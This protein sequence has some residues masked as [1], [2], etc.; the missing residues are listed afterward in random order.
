[1]D[2][3]HLQ[4]DQKD[5]LKNFPPLPRGIDPGVSLAKN[6]I[7]QQ[8]CSTACNPPGESSHDREATLP[9]QQIRLETFAVTEQNTAGDRAGTPADGRG[10]R[11]PNCHETTS[12]GP[13][14]PS[15]PLNPSQE[16]PEDSRLLRKSNAQVPQRAHANPHLMA[17]SNPGAPIG[18]VPLEGRASDCI[19]QPATFSN[20][21]GCPYAPPSPRSPL[22][23][24]KGVLNCPAGSGFSDNAAQGLEND[25]GRDQADTSCPEGNALQ[26]PP[27]PMSASWQGQ[28][29]PCSRPA[30]EAV[31]YQPG[32]FG[33][34]PGRPQR[35]GIHAP[36][37][38]STLPAA[39]NKRGLGTHIRMCAL[40]RT[41]VS[42]H[43]C[44]ES[45]QKQGGQGGGRGRDRGQ[46]E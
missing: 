42:G 22:R 9:V 29:E 17:C 38:S 37:S 34:S 33:G 8:Q 10:G 13:P 19:P 2:T 30:N 12:G 15:E 23:D 21:L 32:A 28:G 1:V 3:E 31:K 14:A 4:Q 16:A 45:G 44:I 11:D 39:S 25:G 46:Q 7:P 20:G 35:A 36:G 40:G 41:G 6:T 26:A 5:W 27:C 43:A 18:G 24:H